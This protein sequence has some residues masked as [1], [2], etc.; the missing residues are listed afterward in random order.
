M[1]RRSFRQWGQLMVGVVLAALAVAVAWATSQGSARAA[2]GWASCVALLAISY[3]VFLRPCVR[4]DDTGV[5]VRN[6]VRDA[7]IPWG[8]V[9]GAG[10]TWSLTVR[11]ATGTVTSWAIAGTAGPGRDALLRRR[12]AAVAG[13]RRGWGGIPET[14]GPVDAAPPG[15]PPPT[16]GASAIA[17]A[18]FIERAAVDRGARLDHPVDPAARPDPTDVAAAGEP[19]TAYGVGPS[20]AYGDRGTPGGAAREARVVVAWPSVGL[21]ALAVVAVAVAVLG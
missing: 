9:T 3:V 17:L 14:V 5:A 11:H 6:I 8:A 12:R 13:G 10:S 21:L 20:T 1:Q 15:A 18:A 19:S 7:D 2:T 16:L 4:V